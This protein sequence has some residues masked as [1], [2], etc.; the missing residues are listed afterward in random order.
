MAVQFYWVGLTRKQRVCAVFALFCLIN[1]VYSAFGAWGITFS[2]A[3][4]YEIGMFA[5]RRCGVFSRGGYVL[6]AARDSLVEIDRINAGPVPIHPYTLG[7]SVDAHFTGPLRRPW[8]RSHHFLGIIIA[9]GKNG[10][11]EYYDKGIAVHWAY[12]TIGIAIWPLITLVKL[13]RERRRSSG[14][15]CQRCDYDLRATP[16][17]CPECGTIP[18]K[19]G[20]KS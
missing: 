11:G 4:F 1:G 17:R 10:V 15:L 18:A 6:I 14:N 3:G 20:L 9:T 16:E 2:G 13:F 19:V 8:Y 5:E 12:P 7:P